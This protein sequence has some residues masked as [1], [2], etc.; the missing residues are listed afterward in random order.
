MLY[1]HKQ[2]VKG[3]CSASLTQTRLHSSTFR[4]VADSGK[5]E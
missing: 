1:L 4:Q 5:D 2:D 3:C